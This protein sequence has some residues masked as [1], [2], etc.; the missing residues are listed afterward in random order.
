VRPLGAAAVGRERFGVK[1][2]G[3]GNANSA[4]HGSATT[5]IEPF[6][7]TPVRALY[8]CLDVIVPI[9]EIKASGKQIFPRRKRILSPQCFRKSIERDLQKSTAIA[10]NADNRSPEITT[11]HCHPKG[12]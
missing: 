2:A 8:S 1:G 12:S 7:G 6:C 10:L 4:I 9:C 5:F 11:S 3:R